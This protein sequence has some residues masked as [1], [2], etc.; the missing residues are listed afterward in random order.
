MKSVIADKAEITIIKKAANIGIKRPSR[1][2]V[3]IAVVPSFTGAADGLLVVAPLL[4]LVE[5]LDGE[6]EQVGRLVEQHVQSE[7]EQNL[8]ELRGRRLQLQPHTVRAAAHRSAG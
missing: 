3:W 5:V 6:V 7:L 2:F 4:E 1:R 8:P